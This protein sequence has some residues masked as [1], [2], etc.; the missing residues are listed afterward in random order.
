MSRY[1]LLPALLLSCTFVS[2]ADNV[3]RPG[4]WEVTTTSKL[5]GL[6]SAI[7]PDQIKDLGDLAK[8]YGLEMPEIQNGAAK[9][10]ACITQ[11][12]AD[13]KVLP[14]S[15]QAQAGCTVKN[16]N[17]IGNHYQADFI[18]DNA[19]FSGSGKAEGTFTT[20]ESFVGKTTFSGNLRGNPISDQANITG[21]WVRN[22]CGGV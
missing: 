18:C 12:M 11:E 20:L 1:L 9:S 3:M 7:P 4:L 21:H 17:R 13:Q 14:E 8:E 5:L 16:V 19:Q 15:F 22:N 2:A 6:V 10:N